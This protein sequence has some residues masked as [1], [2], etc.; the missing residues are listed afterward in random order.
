MDGSYYGSGDLRIGF[1]GTRFVRDLAVD[2][3]AIWDRTT[4]WVR[5][6]LRVRGP[7]GLVG[8]LRVTFSTH[9]PGAIAVIRGRLGG[10]RVDLS[11]PAP[12]SPQG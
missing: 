2:G 3:T 11:T 5:A 12:W 10:R 7:F 1:S 4:R 8:R 6:A 9:A